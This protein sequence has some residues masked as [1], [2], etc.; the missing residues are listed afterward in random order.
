MDPRPFV[1]RSA[2]FFGSFALVAPTAHAAGY[3]PSIVVSSGYA[4]PAPSFASGP[5]TMA[6]VSLVQP[7]QPSST[8]SFPA[9][10]TVPPRHR[11][12]QPPAPDPRNAGP[13]PQPHPQSQPEPRP[14]IGPKQL[15]AC[16]Q[17]QG[18]C[19]GGCSDANSGCNSDCTS[20]KSGRVGGE[21]S[22]ACAGDDM[23]AG[24][25]GS[26]GAK[27]GCSH[28]Q[29]AGAKD[30]CICRDGSQPGCQAGGDKIHKRFGLELRAELGALAIASHI[31]QLGRLGSRIDYTKEGGQSNLYPFA[32]LE[33]GAVINE[34]HRI[35][36]LYQ[37]LDIRTTEV[38]LR[39]LV[40]SGVNFAA[41]R[42]IRY[43][44]FFSFYRLSYFYQW[45][46]PRRASISAGIAG[47]IRN[48]SLEFEAVDGSA[49]R[50]NQDVGFVPLLGLRA[51]INP[52]R[53][54]WMGTEV[55]GFYAPIKYL[56]GG[57]SD[58]EGAILD[59]SLRAGT[60]IGKRARPFL[61][62]RF[63]GGG[64]QGT[65][66]DPEPPGDGYVKNWLYTLS[67]SLGVQW[68]SF[69]PEKKGRGKGGSKPRRKKQHRHQV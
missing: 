22:C 45:K 50:S 37:P 31:V 56:N 38:A 7:R 39:P 54:L 68:S 33:A 8:R 19:S 30:S 58:V 32:R 65:S 16:S 4:H 63:L 25:C 11:G 44:Y 40:V 23:G 60:R 35:E 17:S 61:N 66:N 18:A 67:F 49:F 69:A 5:R 2:L 21:A 28:C 9:P 47:Q 14:E 48:A 27:N 1:L 57:S 59:A 29:Q 52:L 15:C 36:A 6:G 64:G 41:N 55:V 20:N 26:S 3:A 62:I 10:R 12:H 24:G 51:Q 34:R 43:R 46:L 53:R 42:P 13:Q